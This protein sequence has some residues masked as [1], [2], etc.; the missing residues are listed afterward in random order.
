MAGFFQS[1]VQGAVGTAKSTLQTNVNQFFGNPYL[2]D[3]QHADKAFHANSYQYAPK[4]KFLFHVYF[5]IAQVANVFTKD[6]HLSLL[7]KTVKLPSFSM[8]THVMNQYNRKRIVQTKMKYDSVQLTMHDD[9]GNLSRDLWRTYNQY[10]YGDLRQRDS[11]TQTWQKSNQ[12]SDRLGDPQ[13]GYQAENV[14]GNGGGSTT[15]AKEPFFTSIIIYGFNQHNYVLYKLINPIITQWSHDTYNYGEGGGTMEN[16]MTIDYETVVYEGGKI[17]GRN[18]SKLVKDFGE[19]THYDNTPSPIGRPGTNGSILGQGGLLDAAG[20]VVDSLRSNPP[21][22]LGA[23]RTA[24]ITYNTFKNGGLKRAVQNEVNNVVSS[25][26]TTNVNSAIK[27]FTP[28]ATVTPQTPTDWKSP[29][30]SAL[31]KLNFVPKTPPPGG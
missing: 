30:N 29:I 9:G 26:I 25:A 5:E 16:S 27:Y 6:D 1:I 28:K 17:D 10:Y 4:L 8:D 14:L 12:Y 22:I 3:Y 7:V 21:D 19:Q 18:P 20:G 2:R 23:I 24:G 31:N 11:A 13:W 15:G